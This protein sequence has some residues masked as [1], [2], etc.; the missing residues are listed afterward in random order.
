MDVF[1]DKGPRVI[2]VTGGPGTGKGT[3]CAILVEEFGFMHI[4]IGDLMRAE[5]Q[6][7]SEEGLNIRAIV[8]SGNLVPKELTISLL[9][10]ALKSTSAHTVL[11]D[12]FPRSVDQAVYLEQMGLKVDYLLHFD[13]NQEEVLLNRLIERGKTSGRAD[14]QEETIVK[15]F[16]VYKAESLPVLQLYEPFGIVRKIDCLATIPEI[17]HRAVC[18]L[19]PEVLFISGPKF[20]GKTKLARHLAERYYYHYMSM[21]KI[22]VVKREGFR[23]KLTDNEE[24]TRK[25]VKELQKVKGFNRVLLDG[26]PQNLV[27]AQLFDGLLGSPNKAVYLHCLRDVCQDRLLNLGKKSNDYIP[28]TEFSKL[29][30]ESAQGSSDLVAYYKRTLK[31]QFQELDSNIESEILEKRAGEAIEPEVVM[32]RGQIKFPFLKKLENQ[33]YKLV[34]AVNLMDL[35]RNAR[36]LSVS[37]STELIDDPEIISILKNLIF[38]GNGTQKFAIYNFAL[39]NLSLIHDFESKVCRITQVFYLHGFIHQ[40]ADPITEYYY[41]SGRLHMIYNGKFPNIKEI[42][43]E[44]EETIEEELKAQSQPTESWLV[45]VTGSS[46][47][48]RTT[49]SNN[50]IELGYK[51]IDFLQVIEDTKARLSSEE[52]V[53]EELTFSEII[54]GVKFELQKNPYTNIVIDGVPP[55]EVILAKDV[56][57][58]MAELPE[59]EEELNYDEKPI[60]HARVTNVVERFKIFMKNFNVLSVIELKCNMQ[61]MEKRAR[62]KYEIPDEEELN[63][64]QRAEILES[65]MIA[66]RISEWGWLDMTKIPKRTSFETDANSK[67]DIKSR[68]KS[69]YKRKLIILQSSYKAGYDAAKKYA[70]ENQIHYLDFEDEVNLSRNKTDLIAQQLKSNSLTYDLKFQIL[71]RRLM[72]IPVREKFI[73]LAGFP[74]TFEEYNTMMLEIA[75]LEASIGSLYGLVVFDEHPNDLLIER[76]PTRKRKIIKKIEEAK[77]D[78]EIIERVQEIQEPEVVPM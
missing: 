65:W 17:F 69:Y 4:S 32:V 2:F 51:T 44:I 62:V 8:Q 35:W 31:R 58:P 40:V 68:L 22:L 26:F 5:I 57:Y 10:K 52:D 54:S 13:T 38:S 72:T 23:V 39:K 33:G 73:I 66:E 71:Q 6:S 49:V 21:D 28:S 15:R 25:V 7:G 19:R 24:I 46:L 67:S 50:L 47:S 70:W 53:K 41:I 18:T 77:E 9:L 30:I 16:R 56:N 59:D 14:D 63:A 3:Q 36:G 1:S 75:H 12:G 20:S 78:E 48:G 27:Q 42:N 29:W 34:N 37:E 74:I 11:I 61:E 45:F 55:N 43:Q 64:E 76:L 60:L